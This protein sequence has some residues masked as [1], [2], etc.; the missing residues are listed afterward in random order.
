M[1]LTLQVGDVQQT[2]EVTAQTP[3]LETSSA[4]KGQ[5]LSTQMMNTLPFFSGG[6]R[7]PR[8]FV[9][10]LPG[11]NPST[12]LSVSGSGGRAQEILIDGASATIR[13]RAERPST[14]LRGDVRRIQM[15]TSTLRC[16]VRP[17]RRRHRALHHEIGHERLPWHRIPQHAPGHLERQRVGEQRSGR[18]KA[19]RS[20]ER[21]GVASADRFG[22]RRSTMV[23]TRR[24]S[25]SRI[26]RTSG[27]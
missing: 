9:N 13:N 6:V 15:L 20:V 8:S 22:F 18:C 27:P 1:N 11:A 23:G 12:E 24:S 17:V 25:S 19:E 16:G 2:V 21:V 26:R 5:S 14:S 3:L 10:Y 4:Q 7:N